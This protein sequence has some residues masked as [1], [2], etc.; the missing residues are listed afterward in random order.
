[1]QESTLL[2]ISLLSALIGILALFFISQTMQFPESPL[3]EEDQSYT[4]QGTIR[5][6]TQLDKVTFLEI[7][8]EDELT[9]VLFKDYPVD[10][11]SGDYVEAI[12][13]ASKDNEGELQL[14]GK[15]VRVIR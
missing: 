7:E 12:G 5:R 9:I 4:V 10:L 15:E 8:K 14:L 1:M 3:L 2:K 13:K 6:I 11:H